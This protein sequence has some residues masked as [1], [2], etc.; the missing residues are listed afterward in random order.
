MG[1]PVITCPGETFAS[2]ISLS[3]LSSVGLTETVAQNL[4]DYV[5]LA[6]KLAQD[7]PRLANWRAGLREQMASSSLCDGPRFTDN[8]MHELQAVWR[9]WCDPTSSALYP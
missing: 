8:L 9:Q 3:V 7:L 6:A 2:R 5:E 1:V 4:P